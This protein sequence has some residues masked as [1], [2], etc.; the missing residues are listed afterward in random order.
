MV[1]M[2]EMGTRAGMSHAFAIMQKVIVNTWKIMIKTKNHC[3]LNIE[4]SIIY[5]AG[6]CHKNFH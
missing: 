3:I 5:M 1:L 4:M 2:V 6:W